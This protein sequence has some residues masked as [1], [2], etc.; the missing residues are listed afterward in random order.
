MI[1]L[2][3]VTVCAVVAALYVIYGLPSK[4][5]VKDYWQNPNDNDEF[6]F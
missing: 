4:E 3:I 1:I 6:L 5:D 2:T